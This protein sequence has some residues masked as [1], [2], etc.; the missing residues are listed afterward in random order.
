MIDLLNKH[1]VNLENLEMSTHTLSQWSPKTKKVSE[2]KEIWPKINVVADTTVSKVNGMEGSGT[3]AIRM[4]RRDNR[5]TEK[6]MDVKLR[7]DNE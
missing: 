6:R 4:D 5:I 3:N 1:D 2:I 7:W